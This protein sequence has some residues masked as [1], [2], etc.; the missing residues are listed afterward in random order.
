VIERNVEALVKT[1]GAIDKPRAEV[2]PRAST[3]DGYIWASKA[4]IIPISTRA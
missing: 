1:L 4:A 3:T 2:P